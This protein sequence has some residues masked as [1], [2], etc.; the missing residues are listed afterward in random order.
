MRIIYNVI[1]INNII[2][3]ERNSGDHGGFSE[4]ERYLAGL[5]RHPRH[6][7]SRHCLPLHIL[8]KGK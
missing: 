5:H 8:E 4:A 3:A 2:A 6:S 1:S 7:L